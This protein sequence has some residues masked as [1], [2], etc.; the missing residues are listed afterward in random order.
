[1][2]LFV[3]KTCSIILF[4]FDN[5]CLCLHLIE[6]ILMTYLFQTILDIRTICIARFQTMVGT[7]FLY[8]VFQALNTDLNF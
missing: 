5:G 6:S 1:M 3:W 7:F 2:S 4:P 8:V